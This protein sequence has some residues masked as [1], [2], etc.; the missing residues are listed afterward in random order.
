MQTKVEKI[1]TGIQDQK[2]E[3]RQ[4]VEAAKKGIRDRPYKE[5]ESALNDMEKN[6]SEG[7]LVSAHINRW[8]ANVWLKVAK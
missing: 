2:D 8:K 6:L 3:L 7:D 1:K 4:K 5:T